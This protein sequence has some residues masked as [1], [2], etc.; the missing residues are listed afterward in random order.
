M[1]GWECSVGVVRAWGVGMVVVVSRGL[2][3]LV[4]FRWL[5]QMWLG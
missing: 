5:V 1:F 4:G 2:C 3:T